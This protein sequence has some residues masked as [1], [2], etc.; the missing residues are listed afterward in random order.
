[1]AELLRLRG[2]HDNIDGEYTDMKT[3]SSSSSFSVSTGTLL[4]P[5][6][7]KPII[8][9]VSLSLLI[10]IS[11]INILY[12]YL[13]II[14]SRSGWDENISTP[15]ML[16]GVAQF[17]ATILSIY[18]IAVTGRRQIILAG[19][20]IVALSSAILGFVYYF[21]HMMDS[22]TYRWLALVL[23]FMYFTAYNFGIGSV[24]PFV[25]SEILPIRIRATVTSC[26]F[27]LSC[28]IGFI[29]T[30]TYPYTLDVI[31]DYGVFWT[32]ATVSLIC[33]LLVCF[34][35]P[36]TKDKSLEEIEIGFL[37]STNYTNSENG[38]DSSFS[39]DRLQF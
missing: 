6:Y 36:E 12:S 5:I 28:V 9:S 16:I 1:M 30:Q 37:E 31:R 20:A 17:V 35:L 26:G 13:D 38:S 3:L 19:L 7:V 39:F 22:K 29:I 23:I 34:F 14:L 24:C 15:R 4:H 27:P 25:S 21:Q 2:P 32:L 8:L 11:G 18:F 33:F 10:N